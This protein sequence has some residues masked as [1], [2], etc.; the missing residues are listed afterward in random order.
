MLERAGPFLQGWGQRTNKCRFLTSVAE[1]C[2]VNHEDKMELNL[3]DR[4]YVDYASMY[5]PR[6]FKLTDLSTVVA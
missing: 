1:F 4:A 6:Q 5:I 3:K 2:E